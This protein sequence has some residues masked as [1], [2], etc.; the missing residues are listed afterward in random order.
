MF[1]SISFIEKSSES[2]ESIF[3]LFFFA[4]F[5][6]KYNP[7]T[8]DSLLAIRIFLLNFVIE[9]VGLKPTKPGIAE[10]VTSDFVLGKFLKLFKI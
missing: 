5:N 9:I 3:V 4:V 2:I 1:L 8:I 7:Q 10:I 6:I